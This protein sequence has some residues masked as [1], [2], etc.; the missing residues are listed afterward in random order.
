MDA[1]RLRSRL[2][3]AGGCSSGISIGPPGWAGEV[4]RERFRAER[5]VMAA[6]D[7]PNIARALDGGAAPDDRPYFVMERVRGDRIDRYADAHKLTARARVGL[8]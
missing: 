1:G 6:L 3:V 4:A 8:H 2:G 7:H 5:Q